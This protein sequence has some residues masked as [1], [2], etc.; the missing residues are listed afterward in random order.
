MKPLI[1]LFAFLPV[2]ERDFAIAAF[3]SQAECWD[4]ADE[5][6]ANSYEMEFWC[7]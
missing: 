3:E 7:E 4:V 5:M 1:I 6:N 2:D